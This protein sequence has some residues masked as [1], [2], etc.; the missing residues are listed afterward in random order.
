M[1]RI[2]LKR[3]GIVLLVVLSLLALFTIFA[4]SFLLVSGQYRS[5]AAINVRTQRTVTPPDR[6]AE[7]ALMQLL[8]DTTEHSAL[9]NHSLLNDLYGSDGVAGQVTAVSAGP[10]VGLPNQFVQIQVQHPQQ[11]LANF[12]GRF[13]RVPGYYAGRVISFTGNVLAQ[14]NYTS[15]V[16][17]LSARI[18][19]YAEPAAGF[20]GQDD[21]WGL[22]Q[23]STP[24]NRFEYNSDDSAL[25]TLEWLDGDPGNLNPVALPAV[26][27]LFI[28]NG[29][30]FNGMGHG[31]DP[32]TGNI[33]ARFRQP[34]TDF[35]LATADDSI[36][37]SGSAALFPHATAGQAFTNGTGGGALSINIGG[38]D[39]S[40]DTFDYQNMFLA[41]VPPNA[42]SSADI[43]PSFHRPELVYFWYHWAINNVPGLSGVPFSTFTRPYGS[44]CERNTYDDPSTPSLALRDTIV[45]ILRGCTMRPL[46]ED[47][48]NFRW[49]NETFNYLGNNSSNQWDVDNDGDGI[50]DSVWVD[51]GLPAQTAPDG[52]RFRPLVAILCQDLDGRLNLNAH[53]QDG[54]V[55]SVITFAQIPLPTNPVTYNYS[56]STTVST[57]VP[58]HPLNAYVSG[59]TERL[60]RGRG[61]GPAEVILAPIL[62]GSSTA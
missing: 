51:I 34:G 23:S 58:L 44:D 31:Y 7:E 8:R 40:W 43:I 38:A 56:S 17:G 52:K 6:F 13:S 39:E 10:A 42:R 29:Q 24:E 54:M 30:P 49:N 9:K 35:L 14:L 22:A 55:P 37:P 48:P 11:M 2:Q 25:I 27:D 46:P 53:G 57:P 15:P 41:M 16:Q 61:I 21:L 26:G 18:V 60:P 20:D 33:D 19:S 59:N 47:H 28:I 1:K 32:A 50:H 62:F 45:D 36:F 3:R 4:V 5:A 12:P